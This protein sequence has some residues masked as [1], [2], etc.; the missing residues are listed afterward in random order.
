MKKKAQVYLHILNFGLI[1]MRNYLSNPWYR[2]IL[3]RRPYYIAELLHLI[4]ARL[5]D[6][7][8]GQSDLEFIEIGLK[9]FVESF[10]DWN[11]TTFLS[12]M[13]AGLELYDSVDKK[14]EITWKVPV[15][16]REKIEVYRRENAVS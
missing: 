10:P 3:N 8:Y 15:E 7:E 16:L 2:K 4:P 6:E 9:Y 14:F 11:A 5:H 13:D 12:M 1:Y